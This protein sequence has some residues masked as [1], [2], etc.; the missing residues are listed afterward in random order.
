[1]SG[2]F[3]SSFT[4]AI[5][6]VTAISG[7]LVT[8]PA[9]A[10]YVEYS[11]SG[12][13]AGL[14]G[15][16]ASFTVDYDDV[17]SPNNFGLYSSAV[18][19][20]GQTFLS[21]SSGHFH[22]TDNEEIVVSGNGSEIT[23]Y[24]DIVTFSPFYDFA[25]PTSEDGL[26]GSNPL[27]G[28]MFTFGTFGEEK[29]NMI[30][31]NR[32]EGSLNDY[33]ATNR[34]VFVNT[35]TQDGSGG[36]LL[37]SVEE[38]LDQYD[39]NAQFEDIIVGSLSKRSVVLPDRDA[40][41]ADTFERFRTE[42]VLFTEEELLAQPVLTDFFRLPTSIDEETGAF[43]FDP[44][45]VEENEAIIFDPEVAVG[46]SYEIIQGGE[47]NSFSSVQLPSVSGE[48]TYELW[49]PNQDGTAL[50]REAFSLE[51]DL[52]SF[53][54]T[55]LGY[56]VDYFEVTG[57][58]ESL[59]LAPNDPLAFPTLLTFAN[60]GIVELEQTPITVFFDEQRRVPEPSAFAL[61]AIG[62]GGLSFFAN[63]FRKH[64]A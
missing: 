38:Y 19:V 20:A 3:Q 53:D 62:L 7:V 13:V 27:Q 31:G 24:T 49:I 35:W 46:Y 39:P 61:L 48:E 12:D 37:L 32:L 26:R 55:G 8:C 47:E 52:F 59:A 28:M 56:V 16:S 63:R 11:F 54:F 41:I 17:R 51:N 40:V 15:F 1:M 50:L 4:Y 21:G 60:S 64:Q 58:S 30:S 6:V 44:I 25:N 34:V 23:Y 22:L 42:G 10:S 57:I 36:D 14:G 5:L 18:T 33:D 43:V 2:L 45:W 29:S 9:K